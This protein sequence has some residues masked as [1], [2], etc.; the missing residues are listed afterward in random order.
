MWKVIYIARDINIAKN[1]EKILK[2]GE[3]A[4]TLRKLERIEDELDGNVEILV[5]QFEAE[6]AIRLV[7]RALL[8]LEGIEED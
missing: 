1:I 2:K 4:V 5:P 3:I 6:E 7:N 8:T